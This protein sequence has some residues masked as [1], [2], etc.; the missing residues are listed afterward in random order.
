[1]NH[2]C[3]EEKITALKVSRKCLLVLLAMLR[4]RQRRLSE[5]TFLCNVD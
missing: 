3:T 1:M 5:S 4:G 2:F